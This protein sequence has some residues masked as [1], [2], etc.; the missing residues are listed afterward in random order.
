MMKARAVYTERRRTRDFLKTQPCRINRT[1]LDLTRWIY[2]TS[3][4]FPV[5]HRYRSAR[6]T[7]C[8]H[9][10]LALSLRVSARQRLLLALLFTT[11]RSPLAP[12][13]RVSPVGEIARFILPASAMTVTGASATARRRDNHLPSEDNVAHGYPS[14][15]AIFWPR[16]PRPRY[17]QIERYLDAIRWASTS[18]ALLLPQRFHLTIRP[19]HPRIAIERATLSVN[20]P[21]AHARVMRG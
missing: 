18:H 3:T 8:H 9:A 15:A 4:S 1:L 5:R 11:A 20:S 17:P 2:R 14:A 21:T 7:A 10:G 16:G 12:R 13:T 19:L 6:G